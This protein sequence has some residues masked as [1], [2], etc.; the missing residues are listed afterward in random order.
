MKPITV[1]ERLVINENE[2]HRY[3]HNHI[4]D[5]HNDALEP[6]AITALQRKSWHGYKTNRKNGQMGAAGWRN[7]PAYLNKQYQVIV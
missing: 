4:E 6:T 3:E 2:Q 5:G 7:I 1:W